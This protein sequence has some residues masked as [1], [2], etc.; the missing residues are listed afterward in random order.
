MFDNSG[1]PRVLTTWDPLSKAMA[2]SYLEWVF[3]FFFWNEVQCNQET[4]YRNKTI[5]ENRS[6]KQEEAPGG[7]K[8]LSHPPYS[9]TGM[10][11][12][13]GGGGEEDKKGETETIH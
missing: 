8:V 4:G 13:G 6:Y 1:M 5:C 12:L 10:R 2:K 7:L 9:N 11:S 3:V